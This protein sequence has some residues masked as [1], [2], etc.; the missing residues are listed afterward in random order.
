MCL[1]GG[2]GEKRKVTEAEK[3]LIVQNYHQADP[4]L[5]SEDIC[6]LFEDN[7]DGEVT[8]SFVRKWWNVDRHVRKVGSGGHNRV[9][10]ARVRKAVKMCTGFKRNHEFLHISH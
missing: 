7:F 8:G 1:R 6:G 2:G 9:D 3:R 4:L 5:T 10:P